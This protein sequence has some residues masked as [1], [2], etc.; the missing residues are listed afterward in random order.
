LEVEFWSG[1]CV[2]LVCVVVVSV[3]LFCVCVVLVCVKRAVVGG[4]MRESFRNES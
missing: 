3:V 1:I 2:V 4:G